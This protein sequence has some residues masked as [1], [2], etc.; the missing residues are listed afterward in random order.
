M[1][2][3]S[4]K[5]HRIIFHEAINFKRIVEYR[6]VLELNGAKVQDFYLN[7]QKQ[8]V[9]F[10]LTIQMEWDRFIHKLS[11][12]KWW[13]KTDVFERMNKSEQGT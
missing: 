8:N 13:N 1:T 6:E 4:S 2:V 10:H 9:R 5:V 12:T 3:D 7:Y 11:R